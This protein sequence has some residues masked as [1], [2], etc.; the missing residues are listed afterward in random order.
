MNNLG[1]LLVIANPV[2]RS[3]TGEEA[4]SVVRD[5]FDCH[6]EISNDYRVLLTEAQGDAQTMAASAECDTVLAVGG[7]GIIHEVV[8][9]L[10]EIPEN[11]R[12]RLVVVPVGTGNDFARTL[13]MRRNDPAT[14]LRQIICGHEQAIDLGLVDETTYFMQTLSFGLDAAIAL[15][16]TT[17]RA[18]GTSQKGTAL[19]AS[20]GVKIMSQAKR[21]WSYR[22]SAEDAL[23]V[24][25]AAEGCAVVFA[26]QNG[27]TYGAGFRIT[28]NASPSD[29]LLDVCR[30]VDVPRIPMTLFVFGMARRG[31]HG[32]SRHLAFEQVK[33][34]EV[35]FESEPPTQIDG[36]ALHGKRHGVRVVPQALRIVFPG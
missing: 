19:F 15:D 7:D 6:P 12:P 23:G 28:P 21:G 3:G 8:N 35:E 9:G 32:F 24:Q 26:I 20:S 22:V 34:L 14:A 25:S 18:Q 10:M 11:R 17:R 31:H 33:S 29:G 16:T 36:E 1:A 30:S 4:I 5:M 13:G 2:A 27:P